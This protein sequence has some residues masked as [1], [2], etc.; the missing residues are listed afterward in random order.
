MGKRRG[1]QKN[2]PSVVVV[3][4]RRTSFRGKKIPMRYGCQST[5][6]G[7]KDTGHYI[8]VGKSGGGRKDVLPVVV[9]VVVKKHAPVRGERLRRGM[10]AGEGCFSILYDTSDWGSVSGPRLL[11]YCC[12]IEERWVETAQQTEAG[13]CLR[14]R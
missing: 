14:Q 13:K 12:C 9:V 10:V 3:V 11:L 1:G 5:Y 2:L 6:E 7:G 4:K 8:T